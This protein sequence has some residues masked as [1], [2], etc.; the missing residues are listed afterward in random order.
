MIAKNI[1]TLRRLRGLS[2]EELAERVGVSRQTVAKWES[3]ESAPDLTSCCSLAE[4]F[5]VT[6]DDLV[7]F[8]DQDTGL[9]IPPRGKY[10][11][12]S[13]TVGPEGQLFLPEK[14]R[15]L[16]GI[17]TGDQ[18]LLLGDEGR[19]LALLHQRDLI[20]FAEAAGIFSPEDRS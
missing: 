15:T 18:L 20:R 2:Q 4:L 3:G 1:L 12:G 8:D 13:L 5:R 9:V 6:L 10:F 11:F 17:H 14:A 16:F 7:R 19:G